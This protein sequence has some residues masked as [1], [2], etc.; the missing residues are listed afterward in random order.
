MSAATPEDLQAGESMTKGKG[1]GVAKNYNASWLPP[2]HHKGGKPQ[3][4]IKTKKGRIS[5]KEYG[6]TT[7]PQITPSRGHDRR[8]NNKKRNIIKIRRD[9]RAEL[10][11]GVEDCLSKF[12]HTVQEEGAV[13][14]NVG[15]SYGGGQQGGGI[16]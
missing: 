1:R 10:N 3:W 8:D 7:A 2:E 9:P 11:W 4:K 5:V 14:L 12:I 13:L 16:P 15:D 6:A